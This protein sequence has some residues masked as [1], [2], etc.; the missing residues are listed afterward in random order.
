MPQDIFKVNIGNVVAWKLDGSLINFEGSN[1]D[2]FATGLQL[3]YGRNVSPTFPINAATRILVASIP[4]GQLSINSIVGPVGDLNAFLTKFGDV[5]L[6]NSNTMSIRP[7][8]IKP[9]EEGSN[10]NAKLKFT[11]SG[12]LM[13]SFGLVVENRDGL[14]MVN[15]TITMQFLGLQTG[16]T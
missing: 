7:G 5:C 9:C 10:A 16:N 2:L 13:T 8:G 3:T 4:Q 12:C 11:L 1:D 14:G 15:S 6:I